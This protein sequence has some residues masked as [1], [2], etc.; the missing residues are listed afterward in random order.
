MRKQL[1]HALL[2]TSLLA[3]SA[4]LVAAQDSQSTPSSPASGDEQNAP[5][6]GGMRHGPPD[7]A[8]R[9]QQ[10]TRHLKLTSDQQTKVQAIFESEQSQ[11]SGLR[12]DTTLS[13]QDRRTKMMDMRKATDAQVRAILDPT[14]QK[15]WDE[16][17]ARREQW[18]EHRHHGG[19]PSDQQA[20]PS[21]Q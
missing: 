20:P 2:A 14:Q 12:E 19:P 10:L 11:M 6:N 16:M 3:A 5:P 4:A 9:T 7:P 15:K 18:G 13:Q 17:Q 8:E 1:I 21:Q